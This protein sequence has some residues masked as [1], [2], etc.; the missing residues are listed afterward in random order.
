MDKGEIV[1]IGTAD[2][3]ED[4]TFHVTGW[5]SRGGD[6]PA[7]DVAYGRLCGWEPLELYG[8]VQFALSHGEEAAIK[9]ANAHRTP[10]Q[11]VAVFE[12]PISGGDSKC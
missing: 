12:I 1:A 6:Y 2:L 3:L 8:I 5:S 7:A 4:G 10:R 11:P 9:M